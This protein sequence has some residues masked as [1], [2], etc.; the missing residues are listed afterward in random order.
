MPR[1]A[2]GQLAF[3]VARPLGRVV[4]RQLDMPI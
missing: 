1:Q 3:G 4:G 2:A